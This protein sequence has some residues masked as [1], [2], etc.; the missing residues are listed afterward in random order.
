LAHFWHVKNQTS[1]FLSNISDTC[2]CALH[3]Y[4]EGRLTARSFSTQGAV[5]AG[6]K[7]FIAGVEAETSEPGG[8]SIFALTTMGNPSSVEPPELSNCTRGTH[9]VIAAT[10]ARELFFSFLGLPSSICAQ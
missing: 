9:H 8:P 4:E 3:E 1:G 5:V 7:S 6:L 2:V 10:R